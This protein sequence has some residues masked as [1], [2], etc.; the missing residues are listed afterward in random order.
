MPAYQLPIWIWP[1]AL[2][3]VCA[4]S[5]WRG[6]DNERLGAAAYLAAWALSLVAFRARSEDLQ[7]GVL[8]IDSALLVLLLWL[9]L[10]SQRYWPLF[11]AAF[12]LL[13]V[14]T[15]GA[16]LLDSGVSGWAYVTAG[17]IWG[18]LVIFA[19]GYGAVTA[20]RRY[21]EID[22]TP[23]AAPGATRR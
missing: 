8:V 18:Y 4:L 20:P 21:A 12:Q 16:R 13:A 3:T 9:A 5:A 14:L 7:I 19:I 17:V 23:R 15:H 6:R 1:T 11:A 10:R 22:A 2:M